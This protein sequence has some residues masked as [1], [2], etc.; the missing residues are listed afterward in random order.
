VRNL[1]RITCLLTLLLAPLAGAMAWMVDRPGPTAQILQ[2][3][4]PLLGGAAAAWM[5]FDAVRRGPEPDYLREYFSSCWERG[6]LC[7]AFDVTYED[8]EPKL[9]VHFQN[10]FDGPASARVALRPSLRLFG[11][12][13]MEPIYVDFQCPPAGYDV[14][15]VPLA[16]PDELRGKSVVFDV[17]ADVRYPDGKGTAV[18]YREG[19]CV[20]SD[21]QFRK[22][23]GG[24]LFLLGLLGGMLVLGRSTTVRL[25]LPEK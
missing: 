17:G 23:V 16:V 20:R 13:R 15:D 21:S 12:P 2:F 8:A 18:R 24:V 14:V 4:G 11:R 25:D 22:R 5:I 6:G 3:A 10:R 7:F 1:L 19:I 9:E